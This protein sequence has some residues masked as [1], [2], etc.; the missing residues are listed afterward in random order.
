MKIMIITCSPNKDGL[1]EACGK[2]AKQGVEKGKAE[3]VIVRL[4]D[5]KMS[6]CK[7]CDDGWGTCNKTHTCRTNDDFQSLHELTGEVDGYVVVTPVYFGEM[8]ESAKTFFDR[9]RRCEA[10]GS[11]WKNK[12]QDKPYIAIA[13][14]GGS[15]SGT[16]T[17]LSSIERM[18]SSMK[19][20][21]FDLMGVTRKN[22]DYM[23]STIQIAAEKM[24]P[25]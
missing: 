21:R 2:A 10:T 19:A 3:A 16:I 4:N 24:L 8:S 20:I 7:A 14:A 15:G 25:A 23:L 17:C 11:N 9:L 1:T 18:F 13:A 22:K 12:F 5:L 6:S